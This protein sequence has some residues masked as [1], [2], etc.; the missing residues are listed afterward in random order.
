MSKSTGVFVENLGWVLELRGTGE[1]CWSAG[2]EPGTV[3]RE[4]AEIRFFL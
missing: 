2:A 4:N 3:E 1:S